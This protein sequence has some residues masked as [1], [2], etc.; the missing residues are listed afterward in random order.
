MVFGIDLSLVSFNRN[1]SSDGNCEKKNAIMMVDF[2]IDAEREEGLS[3]EDA[4]YKACVIRFRPN[5]DDDHGPR[6][7]ALSHW[8][9]ALAPGA[10]LRRPLGIAVVGGLLFS[11]VLTLY[12][13]PVVY[14]A[15]RAPTAAFQIPPLATND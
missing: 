2:A 7:W 9:S 8:L 11:Q 1:N 5:H 10:E 6:C 12:T 3:P 14:L 13:T 4:I 15:F